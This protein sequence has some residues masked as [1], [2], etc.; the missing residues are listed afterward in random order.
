MTKIRTKLAT[1]Q[2]TVFEIKDSQL[3]FGDNIL[4]DKVGRD[5]KIGQKSS[6]GRKV[7]LY[8]VISGLILTVVTTGDVW[9]SST[10]L[11]FV[12]KNLPINLINYNDPS[13][14]LSESIFSVVNRMEELITDQEK[15]TFVK[16]YYGM[17]TYQ[18]HGYINI[19]TLKPVSD[20]IHAEIKSYEWYNGEPKRIICEFDNKWEQKLSTLNKETEWMNI[21]FIGYIDE[22]I[23]GHNRILLSNC[24]L[25]N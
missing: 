8:T 16:E 14:V 6:S 13:K 24:S 25:L 18:E 4:G 15:Q 5:K 2:S 23:P 3:H 17:R 1:S 22:Y 19:H 11:K 12:Q 10:L 9:W 21:V 20:S 7:I